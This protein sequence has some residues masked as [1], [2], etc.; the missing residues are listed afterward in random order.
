MS[1]QRFPYEFARRAAAVLGSKL[2]ATIILRQYGLAVAAS[3]NDAARRCEQAE[4]LAG[5][6]PCIDAIDQQSVQVVLLNTDGQEWEA[7]RQQATREGFV[8]ALVVPAVVDVDVDVALTLY[9]CSPDR[10]TPEL[11]TAADGY[12]Q[13]A[14]AMVRL[15]LELADTEGET[16]GSN[17][18]MA[19]TVA[20]ERA[21]GA[22]MNNNDGT[23]REA[24]QI[25]ESASHHRNVS[26]REVAE[27]VLRALVASDATPPAEGRNT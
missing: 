13:L 11:I 26:R 18:T 27:T 23:E 4:S 21:V 22:I 14:A 25:L 1:I 8:S 16:A 19:D 15:H 3:S 2:E 9:S 7:W 10:W 12:T 6:G 17:P 20:T 24:R 5:S